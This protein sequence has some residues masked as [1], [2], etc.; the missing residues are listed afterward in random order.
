MIL[1]PFQFIYL[2]VSSNII[3]PEPFF[4]SDF[5]PPSENGNSVS[6]GAVVGIVAAG[7]FVLFLV[8]GILWWKGCLRQKNRMEQGIYN[9]KCYCPDVSHVMSNLDS[10]GSGQ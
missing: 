5:I 8:L 4:H 2:T 3:S 10:S 6:V 1:F 7:A 9:F